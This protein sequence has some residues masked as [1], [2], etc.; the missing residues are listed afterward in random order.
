MNI[1]VEE[2]KPGARR[3]ELDQTFEYPIVNIRSNHDYLVWLSVN[4][5]EGIWKNLEYS[6]KQESFTKSFDYAIKF[7]INTLILYLVSQFVHFDPIIS[8]VFKELDLRLIRPLTDNDDGLPDSVWIRF[9]RYD[10][11]T[12]GM[13]YESLPSM[14]RGLETL[15][16]CIKYQILFIEHSSLELTNLEIARSLPSG[17][18][19]PTSIVEPYLIQGLVQTGNVYLYGNTLEITCTQMIENCFLL[20]VGAF[21][22]SFQA[23]C[24]SQSFS[25][26]SVQRVDELSVNQRE[27]WYRQLKYEHPHIFL[28]LSSRLD[29]SMMD[30]VKGLESVCEHEILHFMNCH[31]EAV[32]EA[33]SLVD[34]PIPSLSSRLEFSIFYF[35]GIRF[36]ALELKEGN[37]YEKMA[38]RF[39]Q[40][41]WFRIPLIEDFPDWIRHRL[42]LYAATMSIDNNR[43]FESNPDEEED[44]AA[45]QLTGESLSAQIA[46]QIGESLFD[47][48]IHSSNIAMLKD[49]AGIP[50]NSCDVSICS[51]LGAK[52]RFDSIV[53]NSLTIYFDDFLNFLRSTS[54]TSVHDVNFVSRLAI[55]VAADT[56]LK[57]MSEA[58]R[59]V[60]E[61]G[62]TQKILPRVEIA[63]HWIASEA[64]FEIVDGYL[65]P[66]GA[67]PED[68]N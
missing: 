43:K 25:Q 9:H 23:I 2:Q 53:I 15:A 3:L 68:K 47:K 30:P 63:T 66:I 45:W 11:S 24:S 4:Y 38:W 44:C 26:D 42:H 18:D 22:S 48:R 33:F 54:G 56:K 51:I 5:A 34:L 50:A 40:D 21:L 8:E 31:W 55:E 52:L 59:I 62:I 58:E 27:E 36:L 37:L 41:H 60:H 14:R 35:Q 7:E 64:G 67:R 10:A 6:L 16:K 12:I 46:M 57:V 32:L 13:T 61:M 19:N 28:R 17:I 49:E 29:E 39:V 20:H 1:D 65:L